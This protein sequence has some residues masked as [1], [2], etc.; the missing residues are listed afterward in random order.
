MWRGDTGDAD[1]PHQSSWI[2]PVSQL[3]ASDL[4]RN[5]CFRL[6]PRP[7]LLRKAYFLVS[8]PISSGL[9]APSSNCLCFASLPEAFGIRAGCAQF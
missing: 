7:S 6:F 5:P 8:K 4:S 3:Q 2:G 9:L 1:R